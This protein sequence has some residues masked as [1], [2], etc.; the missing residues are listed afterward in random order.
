M[1]TSLNCSMKLAFCAFS[2][3]LLVSCA[4][5][6]S[7]DQNASSRYSIEPAIIETRDVL[8]AQVA[9]DEL[10]SVEFVPWVNPWVDS[11]GAEV[12][13]REWIFT[14][15]GEDYFRITNRW[16]G[17]GFSMAIMNDGVFD[18]LQLAA[19]SEDASQRW[20]LTA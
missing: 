4:E 14:D 7:T 12:L 11:F 17:D 16:I 19:S 18:K 3:L 9:S 8:A 1:F 6:E 15:V 10:R 20:K 5:G 13:R 2:V